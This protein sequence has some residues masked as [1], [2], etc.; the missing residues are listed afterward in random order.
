MTK[1]IPCKYGESIKFIRVPINDNSKENIKKYFS[2]TN[3]FIE[4]VRRQNGKVLIHCQAGVSRSATIVL[5]YLMRIFNVSVNEAFSFVVKRRL[6]IDVRN[7]KFFIQLNE[8]E[9]EI[10]WKVEPADL[11]MLLEFNANK[12]PIREISQVLDYLY[13]GKYIVDFRK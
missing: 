2:I 6:D 12:T 5:A 3:S 8:Y 11:K 10:F 4:E 13:I 9:K 7:C 1:D